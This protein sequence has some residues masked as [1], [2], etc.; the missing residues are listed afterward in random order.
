MKYLSAIESMAKTDYVEVHSIEDVNNEFSHGLKV[1]KHPSH[2]ILVIV[3]E[4]MINNCH[5]YLHSIKAYATCHK[6]ASFLHSLYSRVIAHAYEHDKTDKVGLLLMIDGYNRESCGP[7]VMLQFI[8]ENI[9]EI[10]MRMSHLPK[11]HIDLYQSSKTESTQAI[12]NC[13]LDPDNR[14]YYKHPEY[15]AKGKLKYVVDLGIAN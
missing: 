15:S 8:E 11:I 14:R 5:G 2:E 4:G 6:D 12:K 13:K 1:Y 10:D 7:K 3:Q 9:R